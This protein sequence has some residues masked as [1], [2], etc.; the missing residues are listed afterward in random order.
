MKERE[1]TNIVG[2]RGYTEEMQ[3]KKI[4]QGGGAIRAEKRGGGSRREQAE[5]KRDKGMSKKDR[6]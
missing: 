6:R 3:R 1:S 2:D 5:R 4:I